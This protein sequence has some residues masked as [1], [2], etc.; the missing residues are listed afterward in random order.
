MTFPITN[1]V[2][3]LDASDVMTY[4]AAKKKPDIPFV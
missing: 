1:A 2:I 4:T 3:A